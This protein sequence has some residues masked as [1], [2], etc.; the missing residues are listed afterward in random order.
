MTTVEIEKINKALK[1]KGENASELIEVLQDIQENYGFLP[2]EALRAVAEKL[3]VPLIE[4][5]RVASFYKAFTLKPRGKHLVTVC[6]GTAC[7]VRGAP[8]FLDEVLGQL[9]IKP[10]ETTEDGELTVETVNCLGACALGPVVVLDGKYYDH[11]TPGKLRGLIQDVYDG[12][13]IPHLCHMQG[14]TPIGAC[15]ICIVEVIRN[16]RVKITASCTLE[17]EE[18]LVILAH[19]E[20]ILKARKNIAEMLVAQAPNSRAVQDVALRCGVKAVRYPFRNENCVLCGRCVRVCSEVWQS[21]SL[22]FVGRGK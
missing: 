2:E 13:C 14:V 21:K 18:D 17:V 15:R 11:M 16:G 1:G 3:N 6:M 8:K 12:I 7:H 19:T 5:F 20:K 10:G 9:G 4:V 22:G